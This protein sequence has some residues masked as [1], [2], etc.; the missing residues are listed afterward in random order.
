MTLVY[1]SK[2]FGSHSSTGA[3]RGT[4]TGTAARHTD[5]KFR[6]IELKSGL[7]VISEPDTE[8]LGALGAF[9]VYGVR[10]D[11]YLRKA[12]V[13]RSVKG[14]L[15]VVPHICAHVVFYSSDVLAI[16]VVVGPDLGRAA[17]VA[18]RI[19]ELD[20]LIKPNVCPSKELVIEVGG[21]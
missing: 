21:I 10:I 20:K 4:G 19:A 17:A 12:V 7:G 6:W 9:V 5:S 18:I 14:N 8:A 1:V 3:T 11:V 16:S 15:R 13:D 2:A